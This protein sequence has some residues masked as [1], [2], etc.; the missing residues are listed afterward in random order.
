MGKKICSFFTGKSRVTWNPVDANLT[1]IEGFDGG[2]AIVKNF[3]F[4][5]NVPNVYHGSA[6]LLFLSLIHI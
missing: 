5:E 1:I 3:N 4:E 2:T 6:E